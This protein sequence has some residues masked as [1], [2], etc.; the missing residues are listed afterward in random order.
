MNRLVIKSTLSAAALAVS[1]G[2][3][4]T[5]KAEQLDETFVKAP[6]VRTEAVAYSRAEL[7]SEAGRE[8]VER[9]IEMAAKRVCGVESYSLDRNLS[10]HG[11][12]R[13]CYGQAVA[14]ALSEVTGGQ[15]ASIVR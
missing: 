3:I 4:M 1:L 12:A 7:A 14:Q 13:E 11:K 10:R 9:R 6:G 8:S 2:T 5:A 15:V